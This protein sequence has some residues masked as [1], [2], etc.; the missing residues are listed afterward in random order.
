MRA[1]MYELC[2]T[3]LLCP[4]CIHIHTHHTTPHHI[5]RATLTPTTPHP[6]SPHR[7][8]TTD[9]LDSPADLPHDRLRR[10][11]P[12][13]SHGWALE[14]GK[15]P[16]KQPQGQEGEH[17]QLPPLSHGWALENGKQ[18]DGASLPAEVAADAEVN[19]PNDPYHH[20]LLPPMSHGWALERGDKQEE[21]G[22][23]PQQP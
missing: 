22:A 6:P 17:R 1:H 2:L 19:E 10:R 14:N 3:L 7:I 9:G 23:K 5:T 12:P 20:R 8:N 4:G 15:Q 11:Q 16:E 13:L 21:Q 18:Q